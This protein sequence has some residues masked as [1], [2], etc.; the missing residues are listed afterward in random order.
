[1]TFSATFSAHN[2]L[3]VSWNDKRR[4]D[5]IATCGTTLPASE[6][7]KKIRYRN[8]ENGD[9][10]CFEKTVP[11]PR[12]VATYF[13]AAPAT[14]IH[15]HLRQGG[16]GLERAWG[17][18]T[19]WHRPI[20]TLLGII[21]V[22]AFLA[23]RL[24]CGGNPNEKHSL[25]TGNLVW[26]LL[27]NDFGAE[28]CR[29]RTRQNLDSNMCAHILPPIEGHHIL[30][31]IRLLAK[32]TSSGKAARKQRDC[33]ICHMKASFYCVKCSNANNDDVWAICGPATKRGANCLKEHLARISNT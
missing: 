3:A 29:P 7:A 19:W 17:T 31:S 20:A 5:F 12:V 6:P 21:E 11:W 24:F 22:D 13:S 8:A 1:V 27:H 25:F 9:I 23:F 26:Q 28:T 14:D 4:K 15:N 2:L 10:E 33:R 18:H 32:Y 16:L 30:A